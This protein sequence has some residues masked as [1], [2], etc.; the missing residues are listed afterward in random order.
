MRTLL[1]WWWLTSLAAATAW[2]DENVVAQQAQ[3]EP[4]PPSSILDN[5]YLES[6]I[7]AEKPPGEDS[8]GFATLGFNWGIP[9]TSP[10]DVAL[11]LQ[12]GGGVKFRE[13]DPEWNG[14]VGAFARHFT[15]FRDQQGAAAL[16][17]DYRRTAFHNHLW[18]VRPLF[19]TT[20]SEQD[21]LG[22]AIV[23]PLNRMRGQKSIRELRTFW[24]RNWN[25]QL[26][27]QLG[28]G[29]Q[30]SD[31]DEAVLR[32]RLAYGLAPKV[33]IGLGADLNTAGHYAVGV[34][35]SYHFGGT[36]RHAFLDNIGGEGRELYTPFPDNSF[37]MLFHRTK[38]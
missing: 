5:L 1:K 11:G 34:T 19:G 27:T 21:A 35:V 15:T 29:Y 3:A 23:Q 9:L 16:L 12:A 4:A 7:G 10:E 20:I 38:K 24:T 22:V 2:G 18:A 6:G 30:F 14:T 26:G 36:W 32:T 33:D 31:L 8:T 37:P 28:L 25:R 17:F 13:D